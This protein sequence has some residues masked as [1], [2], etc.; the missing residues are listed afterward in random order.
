M[1][2]LWHFFIVRAGWGNGRLQDD[3]VAVSSRRHV[4]D[5]LDS[6]SIRMWRV[7]DRHCAQGRCWLLKSTLRTVSKELRSS[8]R[9][10]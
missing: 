7:T 4:D 1:V 3:P 6:W 8:V 2:L 5:Q 9:V 10:R